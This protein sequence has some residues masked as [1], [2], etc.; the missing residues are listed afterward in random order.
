MKKTLIA[1][2]S[3][4]FLGMAGSGSISV[5]WNA[6]TE[7]DLKGYRAFIADSPFGYGLLKNIPLGETHVTNDGKAVVADIGNTIEHVWEGLTLGKTYYV[8][9]TA[10][11]STGNESMFSSEASLFLPETV[12]I[13]TI[14]PA[15]PTGVEVSDVTNAVNININI[16]QN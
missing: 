6:N 1:L 11:D 3:F 8:A 12:V 7:P 4:L 14:P 15:I 9:V 13:D 16:N 2:L 5:S 10:Y